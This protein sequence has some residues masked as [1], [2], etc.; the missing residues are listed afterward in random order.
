M[1][2]GLLVE[3]IDIAESEQMVEAYG[4]KIPVLRRVA[5]GA[6][7]NWPFAAQQVQQFLES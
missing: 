7:L 6:E 3:V 1:A 4:L 5:D 2:A